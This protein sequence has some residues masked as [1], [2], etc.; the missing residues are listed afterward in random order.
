MFEP[1]KFSELFDAMRGHA[2]GVL[3]DFEVGSVTRTLTEAFA[4]EVALLYEKMQL[5]YL[6]GFVDTATGSQLDNV[7]AVLGVQ[8]G[9]PDFAEGSIV[10]TRDPGGKDI[11]IPPG[12][13]VATEESP[14]APKKVY[15]T[16]EILVVSAD[17]TTGEVRIQAVE[18]G[19]QMDAPAGTIVVLPRPVPGIKSVNNTQEV[20]LLGKRR[21]TDEALRRRAKN[22]LLAAGKA[23]KFAIENAL[24]QLPKV[25]D[26]KVV[27]DFTD[28]K[29]YG[30]VD[31]FIDHPDFKK[32][33]DP[34][35]LDFERVVNDVRAA[36]ILA[37]I[38]PSPVT[39]IV[40]M[41]KVKP[42]RSDLTDKELAELETQ[43]ANA[44]RSYIA[45]IP[46]NEPLSISKLIKQ[47]L[48]TEGVDS[49]ENYR[50]EL[51]PPGGTTQIKTFSDTADIVPPTNGRFSI[52]QTA[53]I[54]VAGKVKFIQGEVHFKLPV[55]KT[56]SSE[57]QFEPLPNA[58]ALPLLNADS[59]A[60][61]IATAPAL[62]PAERTAMR[63]TLVLLIAPREKPDEWVVSSSY[64]VQYTEKTQLKYL[65][66]ANY[67]N[68][69]GAL[70][71]EFPPGT[72]N[73]DKQTAKDTAQA[74]LKRYFDI[75]PPI[76]ATGDDYTIL[77]DDLITAAKGDLTYT[78]RL[79]QTS[80]FTAAVETGQPDPARITPKGIIL[81][82]GE[83]AR[84]TPSIN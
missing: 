41:I 67:L 33:E 2:S 8:R 55:G 3:S 83:K 12:T 50:L 60:A 37:R 82:K 14:E 31:I 20:K 43:L 74:N 24:I 52:D 40:A 35:F 69:V 46:I 58:A 23:N 51:T 53:D 80:D 19:E 38:K 76:A 54:R 10:F 57:P 45:S 13:L 62:T 64:K 21:E 66:F 81:K 36:G 42:V 39:R 4:F 27:E 56:L 7:V 11:T 15:Q 75:L 26:V 65:A 17:Q 16:L 25:R 30:V 28:P 73:T 47:L 34:V 44:V 79:G 68:I 5:V 48:V 71:I 61:A 32:S 72:S 22:T 29:N 78:L 59:L 18:R 77:F 63:P 6:S 70:S 49:L 84:M 9:L 1:K